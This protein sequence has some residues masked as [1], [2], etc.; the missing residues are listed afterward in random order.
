MFHNEVVQ[1]TISEASPD[2]ALNSKVNASE[3]GHSVIISL[4]CIDL[5]K[6]SNMIELLYLKH[7]YILRGV[8]RRGY[9]DP[10]QFEG[11]GSGWIH[12]YFTRKTT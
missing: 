5:E 9:G 10:T 11:D 3:G 8:T 4:F 2:A 12:F 6:Q 7:G 1:R